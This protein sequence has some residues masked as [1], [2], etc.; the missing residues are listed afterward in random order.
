MKNWYTN[1][2]PLHSSEECSSGWAYIRSDMHRINL[3][4][5]AESPEKALEA[6]KKIA[7]LFEKEYPIQR[8]RI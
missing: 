4:V 5:Y 2:A 6:A 3:D 1:E 8:M 7:E